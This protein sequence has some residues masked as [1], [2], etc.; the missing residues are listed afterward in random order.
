MKVNKLFKK[1]QSG[2]VVYLQMSVKKV[3]N[4]DI[5][6]ICSETGYVGQESKAKTSFIDITA[7]KNIGKKNATTVKQQAEK[8]CL[9]SWNLELFKGYCADFNYVSSIKYNTFP[10]RSNMPM[11]LNK[12]GE[13][14]K[15]FKAGYLQYKK[16]GIRCLAEV[17]NELI[18]LKSREGKIFNVQHI[19]DSVDK[20]MK[21]QVDVDFDGELY[22]HGVP[23]QDLASIVKKDDPNMKLEYHIYDI[24][25]PDLTFAQ[26]RNIM[27][28]LDLSEFPNIK[29]DPGQI[30]NTEDEVKAFHKN[31]LEMGYEGSVYCDPDSTYDFGFR[32]NSKQKL[33]PRVT[34]EYECI[35]HYM[36]KGKMAKQSTLVCRTKDGETFHVKLKGTAQQREKW[37]AEFDETIKG[38]M[39]TVEY[40]KLTTKKVPFEAVGVAIR[41][42]E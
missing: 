21:E 20:L 34:D 3:K 27:L 23:L 22:I 7:G 16:D 39:I 41:D 38:K 40:R 6:Q 33:K 31:A 28:A 29:V 1:T 25:I 10:D 8:E 42:Y 5:Y 4:K 13:E 14:K 24:A 2:K 17:Y 32:T 36:N 30:C 26:R 9:A 12:Y 19:L 35:G 11:L 37:A 18:R 15:V